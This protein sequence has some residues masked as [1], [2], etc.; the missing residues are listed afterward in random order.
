MTVTSSSLRGWFVLAVLAPVAVQS[1]V[2]I[3][4]SDPNVQ[5]IGRFD[6]ASAD[7]V[8][9]D[10]PGCEI[11]VRVK[12]AAAS[13]MTISLGQQH[14][15]SD[16]G[17]GNSRNSG[18]EANAF[19]VW[20]DGLRQNSGGP[21]NATNAT[22]STAAVTDAAAAGYSL[23]AGGG[24]LPAGVHDIR[25]FKATE[26]DWNGGDPIPNY[27]TFNG[28]TV[29]G[30]TTQ[31]GT[32][33]PTRK[34]EFLG[35]SITAGFCNECQV[36]SAGQVR[37]DH[38]E[39]YDETWDHQICT[40]LDAQCHTAAWSGLGMVRNCCGGNTTMPA[41]FN[42]TLATDSGSVWPWSSWTADALVINL[43]TNDGAAA[44]DPKYHYV[45]TYTDLVN[46]ASTHY[47]PNLNVFLACG[48]MSTSY[49]DPVHEIITAAAA[50]GIKAHFLDQR[51][52][53][54]GTF[55]PACCGH[56]SVEVDTAMAKNGAAFIK[57]ALGW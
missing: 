57:Q 38:R 9:F 26:A 16:H 14:L 15:P 2:T 41:I 32:P 5:Y 56:P 17:A 20:V 39:E 51:G 19:V 3:K 4:P 44:T 10:M 37:F 8:R 42:R 6:H 34:I 29:V 52:F 45:Q 48:P 54:N 31:P 50:T 33:L 21:G 25:V 28:F 13:Q 11:R 12:L 30:A 23:V 35:D 43:G 22:F 55:G 47:G 27:V 40:A 24:V 18:F 49:C 36:Q 46:Q 1:S 53:L 7:A